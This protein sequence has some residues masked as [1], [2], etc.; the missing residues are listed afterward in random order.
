MNLSPQGPWFRPGALLLG[1]TGHKCLFLRYKELL[2]VCLYLIFVSSFYDS[3]LPVCT[4]HG[5]CRTKSSILSTTNMRTH[6]YSWEIQR[7]SDI[8]STN[9]RANCLSRRKAFVLS[10]CLQIAIILEW[11][12]WRGIITSALATLGWDAVVIDPADIHLQAL[13]CVAQA[14]GMNRHVRQKNTKISKDNSVGC[15]HQTVLYLANM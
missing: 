1:S 2:L 10:W 4:S 12:P 13:S 6:N 15:S 11:W 7:W 9:N 5:P 8:W 3:P 14:A